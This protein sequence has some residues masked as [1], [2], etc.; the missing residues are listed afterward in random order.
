MSSLSQEERD[1]LS[2]RQFAFPKQREELIEDFDHFRNAVACFH[3]IQGVSD[4]EWKRTL[5]AAR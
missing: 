1:T 3:Y 4:K 2:A 5:A